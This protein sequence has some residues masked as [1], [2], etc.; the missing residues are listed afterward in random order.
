MQFLYDFF[1][2]RYRNKDF[3]E[4]A[5]ARLTLNFC[6]VAALFS[7]LY[8][9]TANL[10]SFQTSAIVMPILATLFLLLAML[11]RTFISIKAISFLYVLVSFV[12]AVI[13]IY[14]SGMI[15]SSVTPWLGFIPLTAN[16]LIN[17]KVATGWL[18][19]CFIAVITF[20]FLQEKYSDIAVGYNKDY[21][22]VFYVIVY[23]GLTAIILVVSMV[24]QNAKDNVLIALKEKNDLISSINSELKS[25]N[26]EINAQNEELLQQKEEI[27]AQREFIEIKNRELLVIQD[28]L[29]VLIDKL[30]NTQNELSGREA[31][32]RSILDAIYGAQLLVRELDLEGKF[33]K[34]GLEA[35]NF[36]QIQSD[37]FIGKSIVEIAKQ[38][39]MTFEG[40][41]STTEMW[42]KI[43]E[44][45]NSTH[46]TKFVINE[47]EYWLKENYFPILG[48]DGKPIKIMIISQDISQIKSQ[49]YEIEV[50][51][52]ELQEKVWKIEHQNEILVSQRNEIETINEELQKSNDEV[53]SINLNL[54]DHVKERTRHLE[55]QNKQLSEYSYINAHLLRG[56]LC[57]ILGLVHLLDR[58]NSNDLDLILF[59]MKKSSKDL[60]AVV[61]KISKAIQKGAHFDRNLIHKI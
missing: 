14:S 24:F 37:D 26:Y 42:Q 15:Y 39:N 13:L 30:T 44:G 34:I 46:E 60:N 50:L 1:L 45:D 47:N 55:L 11:L 2:F 19:V 7:L 28:E 61:D 38:S 56:P 4:F 6:L 21:E 36:F 27:T 48:E 49:K 59:H 41:V 29:N 43:L 25:K 54:E 18:V 5:Q 57:S 3:S 9:I 31:E 17:R 40:D 53:K 51:N 10:I 35:S 8:T 16:L 12:A 58:N 33:I 32:N 20:A 52:V 23:N 22:I